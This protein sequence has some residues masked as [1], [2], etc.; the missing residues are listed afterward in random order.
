MKDGVWMR[1]WQNVNSEWQIIFKIYAINTILHWQYLNRDLVVSYPVP[2][3][4]FALLFDLFLVSLDQ[5]PDCIQEILRAGF[6]SQPV[7]A[8]TTIDLKA[9]RWNLQ[10]LRSIM[11]TATE[12]EKNYLLFNESWGWKNKYWVVT[13]IPTYLNSYPLTRASQCSAHQPLYGTSLTNLWRNFFELPCTQNWFES[14]TPL[15]S[16]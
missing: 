15:T 2:V 14:G 10:C 16:R 7:E 12:W 4:R 9:I 13:K 1:R 5:P 11:L 8:V 6:L 3:H